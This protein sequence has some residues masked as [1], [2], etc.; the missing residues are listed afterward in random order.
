MEILFSARSTSE[1]VAL[2]TELDALRILRSDRE[3]AGS[4]SRPTARHAGVRLSLNAVMLHPAN[5][6]GG[7]GE[8]ERRRQSTPCRKAGPDPARSLRLGEAVD[9]HGRSCG[10]SVSVALASPAR[11]SRASTSARLGTAWPMLNSPLCAEPGAMLASFASLLRGYSI[12]INPP[13]SLNIAAAPAGVRS[14]PGY[15]VPTSSHDSRPRPSR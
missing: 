7:H 3:A 1:Y 11:A 13:V 14:S 2:E 10:R 4:G 8:L 9:A 15:S 6:A 12:S 5:I